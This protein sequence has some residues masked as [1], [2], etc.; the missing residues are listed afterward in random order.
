MGSRTENDIHWDYAV[1]WV[2]SVLEHQDYH[3]GQGGCIVTNN[4]EYSDEIVAIK[5]FGRTVKVG[6]VYNVMGLNFKFT[7]L[8]ASFWVFHK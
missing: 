6:E 2:Y 5:N 1:I 4:K 3:N 7:D 8:Q